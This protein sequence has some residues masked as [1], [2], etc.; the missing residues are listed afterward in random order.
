LNGSAN[1]GTD[2]HAEGAYGR[3]APQSCSASERDRAHYR[4]A[5]ILLHFRDQWRCKIPLDRDGLVDSRS[6][7]PAK[8]RS[9]TEPCTAATRPDRGIVASGSG[10]TD[11]VP[12]DR[13]RLFFGGPR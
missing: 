3:A 7:T 12:G 5:E 11:M 10:E 1:S 13:M 2:R 9:T 6:V 4:R 8:E